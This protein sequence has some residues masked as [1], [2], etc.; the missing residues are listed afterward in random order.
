MRRNLKAF[1]LAL[2]CVAIAGCFGPPS[3]ET[4]PEKYRLLLTQ[5]TPTGL[6]SHFPNSTP[7][8]ATSV[9]LSAFPGFLQGGAWFQFRLTLPPGEVAKAYESASTNAKDFYDGGGFFKSVNAKKGGLPGTS[10]HTSGN[11]EGE[12]PSDYRIF[13]FAARSGGGNTWQ[14]GESYGVVISKERNEVIYYAEKW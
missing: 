4:R 14:A 6:V 11:K 7:T 9:R 1:V 2:L 10:F 12:F 8:N 13:V 5:W 3:T